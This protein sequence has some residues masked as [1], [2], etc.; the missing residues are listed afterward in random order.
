MTVPRYTY[1]K[2]SFNLLWGPLTLKCAVLFAL[3]RTNRQR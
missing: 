1:L 3:R 2:G